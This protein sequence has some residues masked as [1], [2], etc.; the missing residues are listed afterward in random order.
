MVLHSM[1]H[2]NP[3]SD[4]FW[5]SSSFSSSELDEE[6]DDVEE[7]EEPLSLVVVVSELSEL[8]SR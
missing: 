8:E 5:I 6:D 1:C 3:F 2:S 7:Y 4:L